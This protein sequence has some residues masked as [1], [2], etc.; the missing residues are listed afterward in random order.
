MDN[1]NRCIIDHEAFTSTLHGGA[2]CSLGFEGN[3]SEV[4]KEL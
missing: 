2:F 4:L 3:L 1:I